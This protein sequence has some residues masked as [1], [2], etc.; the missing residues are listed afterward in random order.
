MPP[1][2]TNVTATSGH[3]AFTQHTSLPP[4]IPLNIQP[5]TYGPYRSHSSCPNL[6][7]RR[8][9]STDTD[10]FTATYAYQW[11]DNAATT[12]PVDNAASCPA[13]DQRHLTTHVST[14]MPKDHAR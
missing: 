14:D 11:L 5:Q 7:R 10:A 12:L 8:T 9:A 3:S 1:Q 13:D 6:F 4:A 2:P